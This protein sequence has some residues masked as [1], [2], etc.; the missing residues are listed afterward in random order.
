MLVCSAP[1]LDLSQIPAEA[2]WVVDLR[3]DQVLSG[4]LGDAVRE[5][6][7]EEDAQHALAAVEAFT[8]VNMLQ[9]LHGITL[10]GGAFQPDRRRSLCTA[11]SRPNAWC[12]L[13]N[14]QGLR[15]PTLPGRHHPSLAG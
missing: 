8:G 15:Q 11:A 1:A 7:T 13:K 3:V 10:A 2:N 5:R 14:G 6:L 12:W 9:D 4:A